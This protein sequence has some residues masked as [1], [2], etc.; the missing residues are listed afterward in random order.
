MTMVS[1]ARRVCRILVGAIA[2]LLSA[3]LSARASTII[4]FQGTPGGTVSWGGGTSALVGS[5]IAITTV[6]GIDT[7]ANNQAAGHAVSSG[8]LT[9]QTGILSTF[10][11][12]SQT[13]TFNG[14]ASFN[15]YGG[16]ADVPIPDGTLLLTGNFLS[17]TVGN[18]GVNFFLGGPGGIDTKDPRL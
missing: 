16:V 9:F 7:P 10:D 14:G 18:D 13:Y 11:A 6:T 4:D 5:N 12:A 1:S 8:Q 15:I 2:V 3:T 17:A